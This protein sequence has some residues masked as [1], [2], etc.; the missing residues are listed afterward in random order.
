MMNKQFNFSFFGGIV[1][2]GRMIRFSHTIFALPFALSAV[3]LAQR[4]AP[5]TRTKFFWILMA[6][7]GARSSAM[8]FNRI[9]D[10]SFDSKNP[11]TIAR[12]L[13]SG[14]L[15]LF[16]S[17]IFIICFSGLF[18][19]SA[20]QL[21]KLC[22]YLSVPVLLVLFSY[23]L[24]K[25]FTWLCHIYLGFAIS[26][27]PIGAW[28]ATTGS[29]SWPIS[30]LAFALLTYI[31]GFDILYACQDYY[32]D[33]AEGLHSIPAKF[34]VRKSLIISSALHL[35]SFSFFMALYFV[36]KMGKIYLIAVFLIGFF[37]Y[38]EQRLVK[39]HDLSH[40][41]IAFFHM[42]SL[43]SVTLLFGVL[44]DEIL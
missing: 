17:I 32:F 21:G 38:I 19:F 2:F 3:F 42:N 22:F 20:A 33:I 10:L 18:I 4:Y 23:S 12:E 40:I 8:G 36:F 11:R 27:A 28:V 5:L 41:N 6:M 13:P 29:F 35:M 1:T 37:F 25:R 30:L 9:A 43:I 7:V 16:A 34:G 39:P 15:S 14:K 31:A 44:A 26:L 24:T